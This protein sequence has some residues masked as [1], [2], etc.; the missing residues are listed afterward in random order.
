MGELLD[1]CRFRAR[2]NYAGSHYSPCCLVSEFREAVMGKMGRGGGPA[3]HTPRQWLGK[4][5]SL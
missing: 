5:T 4:L 1:G 2:E 3:P